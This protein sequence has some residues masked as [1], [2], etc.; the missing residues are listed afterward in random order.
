MSEIAEA[1]GV[2][3]KTVF[4]YFASKEDLVFDRD[5]ARALLREGMTARRGMAPAGRLPGRWCGSL[6]DSGHPLLRINAGAATFYGGRQPGLGGTCTTVAGTAG[7][8]PAQLMASAVGRSAMTRHAWAQPCCWRRWRPPIRVDWPASR[9]RGSAPS[10]AAADRAQWHRRAGGPAGTPIP[11]RA[12]VHSALGD[13][14]R[15]VANANLSH[16]QPAPTPSCRFQP[17]SSRPPLPALP[18]SL[19]TPALASEASADAPKSGQWKSAAAHRPCTAPTVPLSAPAPIPAE[20]V[21]QSIQVVPREL[22]DDQAARQVTDPT[23]ASAASA[24]AMPASPCAGSARKTC[25]TTACAVIPM[26]ASVPQLFNIERVEVL[27]AR[28]VRCT[29]VVMRAVSSTT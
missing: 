21:P 23:A 25:S 26:Q 6:L 8:R 17:R 11:T 24:S 14:P 22:I 12:C 10:D 27:K 28:P 1:A 18:L 9:G 13:R 15:S 5:E 4:N 20:Q 2:S 19:A 16:L 3:R 29:A 7:R